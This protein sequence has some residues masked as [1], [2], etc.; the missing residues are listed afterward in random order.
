MFLWNVWAREPITW[1]G[2]IKERPW[3]QNTYPKEL[4]Q[5]LSFYLNETAS[6]HFL[7]QC[8]SFGWLVS[9]FSW[10]MHNGVDTEKTNNKFNGNKYVCLV[11]NIDQV[12]LLLSSIQLVMRLLF[13]FGCHTLHKDDTQQ[14]EN[15]TLRIESNI[16]M[17]IVFLFHSIYFLTFFFSLSFRR[18]HSSRLFLS[19]KLNCVDYHW[20]MKMRHKM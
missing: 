17:N 8:S 13:L 5:T 18:T 1:K 12:L 2:R 19:R 9:W 10:P 3:K 15:T 14:P 6:K 20:T 4:L 7:C 11:Y 16:Q